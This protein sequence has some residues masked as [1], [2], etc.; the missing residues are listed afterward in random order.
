MAHEMVLS[1][2]RLTGR[3]YTDDQILLSGQ[4]VQKRGVAR[5]EGRHQAGTVACPKLL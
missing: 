2:A 4:A 5:Q 1:G 3:G